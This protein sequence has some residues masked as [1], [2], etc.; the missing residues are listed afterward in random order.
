MDFAQRMLHL[1]Y[2]SIHGFQPVSTFPAGQM[3][4][5]VGTSE[6]PFVK[7][8]LLNGNHCICASTIGC[9]PATVDIYDSQTPQEPGLSRL[10]IL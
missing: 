2:R 9:P 3:Q 1:Q 6:G 7:I 8:M 4:A 10:A 5:T